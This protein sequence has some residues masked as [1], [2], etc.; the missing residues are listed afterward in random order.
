MAYVLGKIKIVS[1]AAQ[2]V[3]GRIWPAGRNLLTPALERLSFNSQ[4]VKT[5]A[6]RTSCMN[7][8]NAYLNR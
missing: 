8:I 4:L 7:L 6:Y 1:P 2:E 3:A 5:V